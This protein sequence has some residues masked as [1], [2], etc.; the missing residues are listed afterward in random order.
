[1]NLTQALNAALPEIPAH[2]LA[3]RCPRVPPDAVFK[4]HI[5]SGQPVVRVL[6]P[7]QD[8]V[9]RFPPQNWILAQLFDGRRSYEEVAQIYSR[10]IGV[11]YR[12]DDAREF[13]ASLEAVDFWYKTPQEKN[14][15]LMQMSAEERQK[16]LKSRRNKY[17]DLSQIL[18]PAVNPD[19]FLDWLHRHTGYIYT[20]W[21]TLLTLAGFAFMA[22]ITITH[23][24]EIGRD[25]L[26]F[27]NFADKSWGDVAT[28]Y[29]LAVVV[30][31]WHELGHGHACKHYGGR[32]PSMGFLLIYLTPAFYTDTSEGYIKA[33]RIQRLVIS[34]AGVWAE[35]W[36]CAVA[37]VI[38]WGTATDTAV[39]S[40]AYMLMLITGIACVLINWNPLMKLDG[41]HMMCEIL[42]IPD[43]KE[44]S[45]A[46]VSAWVKRHIWGLPVEV[47]YVPRR[48]RLGFGVY[49]LLS[50]LYSYTV[51][52]VLAR[53]IGNV[54][55][56]FNPDWSFIP[57][58]GTGALI[59]R[60]RIRTLV[61]FMKFVYLDKKDRTR[62]WFTPKRSSGI[63]AGVIGVLLL[64]LRHDSVAGRFI[65]EPSTRAVARAMVPGIVAKVYTE[66][67]K[68]VAMGAPLLQLRN[69]PLQS[70]LAR[71]ES[72]YM[73]TSGRAVSATLRYDNFGPVI[74]ERESLARQTS[75]LSSEAG[76]LELKSPISGVVLTPRVTD[77]VGS[78]VTEG[79]ELLEIADLNQ[80]RARIYVSEH[81]MYKLWV[82]ARA[83]LQIEGIPRKWDAHALAISALSAEID[84]GLAESTKYKGLLPPR[85]YLVDLFVP[86]PDDRL[87][88][89]MTGT[90]RIYGQ[91]RSLAGLAWQQI[92]RFFA[93]KLW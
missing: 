50:G 84:Q 22:V 23:W 87:K 42:G 76:N 54:F 1:M 15:L 49:A 28:F 10:Q 2:T 20:W 37:T 6:V 44:N 4:E 92:A 11:D 63:V 66:E 62:A 72:E 31:A 41:Y 9:Y 35:L 86:N 33:S 45:T 17:G 69:L 12:A 53:F 5:E 29:V 47:P 58:L 43:L 38:W 27:F 3:Q 19:R 71:S 64:P 52:Y 82:G 8:A 30:M 24:S 55:R 74:K 90:G 14:I 56:N 61:N 77:R 34:L 89:G 83:S 21:F 25:S 7:S 68:S 36:I 60:S 81:D 93:G 18:F 79:T 65:L 16:L 48:R 32:V 73:V 26:Q 51:L 78:Y 91:R 46:Y 40:V 70:R 80:L 88:P 59:F 85:F 39:H 13:A 57:E 67:G 75:M